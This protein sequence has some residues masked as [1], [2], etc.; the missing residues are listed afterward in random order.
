[1]AKRVVLHVG[2]MKSGTSFI[3]QVL[4]TNDELLRDRGILFPT[5]WRVQVRGVRDIID[6]G[7]R[8]QEPLADDGPWRK[9]MRQIG[10]WPGTVVCSMEFL[11]P[12]G[13]RKVRDILADLP[14]DDVQVVVSVRDLARTIPAMWQENVQNWGH[15]SWEDYLAGVREEDRDRPGS[16]RS[17]W[18][19]QDASGITGTW[20]AEAGREHVTVLTV[21]TRSAPSSLLWERFASTLGVDPE[22]FDLDVPSNPS[23]GLPSLLVLHDLNAR[24]REASTEITPKDYE[25]SVKRLL[26]KKTL[27]ARREP[28]LGYDADWV[29]ARGD[30]EIERLRE[31]GVR[32]VGDLEEL[33]CAPV[34]GISP[35]D[36][37]AEDRLAAALEALAVM[38]EKL[39]G[40]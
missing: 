9:L 35:D 10:D 31:L 40:R 21:P 25:R 30:L 4:R 13:P 7:S 38:T 16:G 37:A 20:L 17:F 24:L 27:A 29:A 28:R 14:T 33:R 18:S 1:M 19:R 6:H 39:A 36:V 2:L 26:A 32:V 22:G 12:R 5:P 34:E 3:Q 23:L 8:G 11:G 15:L